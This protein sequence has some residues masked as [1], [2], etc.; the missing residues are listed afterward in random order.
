M[1]TELPPVDERLVAP[2]SGYE[3]VDGE[4]VEVPP[5]DE[6]HAVHHGALA[7]LL[8][9]HRKDDREVAVDM[10]TRTSR[11]DDMAPDASVFPRARDPGTG[12]RQLEELAFEVLSTERSSHAEEKAAKLV[13]RGVRRVF[14]VDIV[15]R[16][17]L[18]WSRELEGWSVL[19]LDAPIEDDALAIPLPL[20][21]LVDATLAGDATV[22]AFRASRHPEFL[23]EREEGREEGREAGREQG[24]LEGRRAMLREVLVARFGPLDAVV[25]ARILAAS[26]ELLQRYAARVPGA[27][28][29]AEVIEG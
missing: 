13:A 27:G 10:L 28:S 18:E 4:V 23:A 1:R 29:A 16:R 19:P 22:R 20:E 17:V 26:A 7:A 9:A 11:R 14:G 8:L 2:E 12:G 21:P 3:I 6:F 5:A 25:E 24:L 15:R